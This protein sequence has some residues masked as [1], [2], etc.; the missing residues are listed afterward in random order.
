MP[1]ATKVLLLLIQKFENFSAVNYNTNFSLI[2]SAVA[3]PYRLLT[4]VTKMLSAVEKLE[5]RLKY[6]KTDGK[7]R[8]KCSYLINYWRFNRLRDKMKT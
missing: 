5:N 2:F 4:K 8:G 7:S 1:C 6:Y 3:L